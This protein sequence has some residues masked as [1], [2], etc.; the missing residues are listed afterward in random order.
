MFSNLQKHFSQHFNPSENAVN[1]GM[2][3]ACHLVNILCIFQGL[4]SASRRTEYNQRFPKR[5]QDHL[6]SSCGG[7]SLC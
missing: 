7:S 6:P 1:F 2:S 3:K 5:A 4:N